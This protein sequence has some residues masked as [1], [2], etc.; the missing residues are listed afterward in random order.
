MTS[1]QRLTL[2]ALAGAIMVISGCGGG[3]GAQKP[4][5]GVGTSSSLPQPVP[6][7]PPTSQPTQPLF[8]DKPA[9]R[10][11]AARFLNQATFGATSA[12]VDRLM[13]IGYNAW[14]DEQFAMPRKQSFSNWYSVDGPTSNPTDYADG[15]TDRESAAWFTLST[16]EPDQLRLRMAWAISQIF[17][18]SRNK[19]GGKAIHWIDL[20]AD[21]SFG[22]YRELLEGATFS[23][24][25][26]QYLDYINNTDRN[27]NAPDQ[28]YAREVMQ[29]FSIGLWQLNTDGS[30]KLDSA[31]ARIPTYSQAD[32][33]GLSYVF[34]GLHMQSGGDRYGTCRDRSGNLMPP[35]TDEGKLIRCE[36]SVWEFASTREH[37]FL[38]VKI[39]AISANSTPTAIQ[40][41]GRKNIGVALDT[42]ANHPN[43]A[44]FISKQLIQRFTTSN[45]SPAYVS[46]VVAKFENNGQ[47]VRGDFKAVLKQILLDPEARIQTTG[48]PYE[49]GKVREPILAIAQLNRVLKANDMK[50]NVWAG[51]PGCKVYH[52]IISEME[53]PYN[54]A[55]VFNFYRPSFT[56]AN[57][58]LAAENLVAPEM[59]ITDTNAALDWSRFVE[60]SLQRGGTGC[61]HA[62]KVQNTFSYGEFWNESA[63]PEQL[64]DK[65]LTLLAPGAS[66][67]DLRPALVR[68]INSL[69]AVTDAD[70]TNRIKLAIMMTML[71]PEYRVQR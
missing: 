65:V 21:A 44:P 18:V 68:S 51:S 45:P 56:P 22:T 3:A 7:P 30:L 20:T 6:P 2:G 14:L 17:V 1:K 46:R 38:G 66:L 43:T 50:G 64:A 15:N 62:A 61:G 24:V 53:R 70:R 40:A 55:T 34:T 11:D 5:P 9:S 33:T 10:V 41:N 28:N 25:M 71:T 69:P 57:G 39:P 47:G 23:P 49:F 26:A 8:P 29:L 36:L 52:D 32:V 31:G 19:V 42:L 54:S 4:D 35:T 12:E 63:D 16:Q 59:Q 27:G 58:R 67:S 13:S 37:N 48:R 60:Q